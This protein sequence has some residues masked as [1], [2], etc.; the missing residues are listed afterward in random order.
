MFEKYYGKKIGLLGLGISGKA[1]AKFFL[2]R[3]AVVV[4]FESNKAQCASDPTLL[5]LQQRGLTIL[6]DADSFVDYDLI[7]KSPGI[8]HDHPWVL[9]AKASQKNLPIIG[10]MDVACDQLLNAGQKMVA[11]TGS[12]GKTTTVLLIKHVLEQAGLPAKALGNIGTPP[13]SEIDAIRKEPATVCVL[14]LSSFQLETLE[15]PIFDV[16]VILNITPNHLDRYPSFASYAQAK[17]NLG[18]CIKP[19]GHLIMHHDVFCEFGYLLENRTPLGITYGYSLGATCFCDRQQVYKQGIP[20]FSLPEIFRGRTCHDVENLMA[21]YLV[22]DFL[23][24]KVEVFLKALDSFKKPAHRIEFVTT[25]QGITFFNDSKATSVDA[26]IKAVQS[27]NEKI[28]LIAGGVDKGGSYK[29]WI[30]IFKNRVKKV[31]AIGRASEKIK[32][33]LHGEIEIQILDDLEGAVNHAFE[34][35]EAGD[36]ILLSPGCSSYDMF[37]DYAHRGDEFKRIV[38]QLTKIIHNTP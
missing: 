22:C 14:E 9:K 32:Q 26:V 29:P 34:V 27:L 24:I 5:Q 12:N 15:I 30:P 16:A 18:R 36:A 4:G 31:C 2:D 10:E 8:A 17:F 35:A 33:E 6:Q 13:I 37:K 38:S 28:I 11:V 21:A 19:S 1:C 25:Y 7:V 20:M 23:G 3:G